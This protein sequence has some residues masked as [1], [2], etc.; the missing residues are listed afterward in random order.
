VSGDQA[1]V[2]V[3][4]AVAPTAA[5]EVFT[6]EIDRWWRRG[7]KF[8]NTGTRRGF[9]RV[10]PHIGG[11]IFESFESDG[12]THVVQVGTV[13]VWEPARRLVF[14]WRNANFAPH[15]STE[16]EVQ[17]AASSGGTTV[18]LTHRGWS[19]LREDHPARHGLVGAEFS[20]M[21]GF[22]WSEQLTSLREYAKTVA[23]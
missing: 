16:V 5:F 7:P 11:R 15:E 4:V 23:P 8:R 14:S 1:C 18:T 12:E 3:N 9:I 6:A 10:E 13:T 2:T 22:W 20:R 17:F 19:S 21:I